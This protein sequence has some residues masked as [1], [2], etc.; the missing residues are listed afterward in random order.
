MDNFYSG[1]CLFFSLLI[2]ATAV[3]LKTIVRNK[4]NTDYAN[5]FSDFKK[6]YENKITSSA[7][8]VFY[9]N[10][11]IDKYNINIF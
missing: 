1:L 2:L 9:V 8:V 4:I 3:N 7:D 6:N 5:M 11:F 10:D